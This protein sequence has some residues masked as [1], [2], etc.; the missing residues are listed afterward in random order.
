[1]LNKKII[2]AWH[3]GALISGTVMLTAGILGFL[4]VPIDF[5]IVAPFMFYGGVYMIWL[6]VQ[7]IRGRR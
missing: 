6:V 7:R 5:L 4:K 1:M 3:I 2:M